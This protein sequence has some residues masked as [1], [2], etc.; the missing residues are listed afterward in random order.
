[1]P[2]FGFTEQPNT[3][4]LISM[5]DRLQKSLDTLGKGIA[6]REE[7]K[8]YQFP[9]WP[10][11]KRGIPNDFARSALFSARKSVGSEHLR[12]E[13]IFSQGN[14]VITYTGARLT[15]DH[16]DVY[17]GIM[18]L[19]RSQPEG[20]FLY[21]SERGLLKLIDRKTGGAD[22]K[23]LLL[24]L[25]DLTATSVTIRHKDGKVYWGSLLPEG[26]S[27][28]QTGMFKMRINRAL[29]KYFE[30]GFTLVEQAQRKALARSPLA[31]HLHGWLASHA[32][33][34]PATVDYLYRLS[35]SETKQLKHFRANMKK[36]LDRLVDVGAL[37]S[38]TIDKNDMVHFV[39]PKLA[40]LT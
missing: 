26:V 7:A 25:G 14:I 21:C 5:T 2:S 8:I 34:Y 36:A 30:K 15:Q 20:D 19:A 27:D 23:R 6:K 24:T 11:P 38:W 17:E 37:E 32:K 35:G 1:M 9:L 39:K 12:N 28:E 33:P 16:L 31:K 13:L 3:D 40:K 18:H 4:K 29:I 22:H 10:E